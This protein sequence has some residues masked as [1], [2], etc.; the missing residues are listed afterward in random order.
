M[1]FQTTSLAAASLLALLA[2][3]CSTAPS[4]Q[5]AAPATPMLSG[6]AKAALA[7]AGAAVKTAE[8]N[9]TLW[10]PVK[11]AYEKA[12]KAAKAGDSATVLKE[13]KVVMDLNKIATAQ[14]SYPSTE[15]K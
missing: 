1:R 14:A 5:A 11:T 15:L 10:I 9:Y 6:E 13:T 2:A 4:Q 3:G 7:E 12:E 8:A